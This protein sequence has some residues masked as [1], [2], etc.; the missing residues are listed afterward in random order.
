MKFAQLPYV[1]SQIVG[2]D[3]RYYVPPLSKSL[4]T[5]PPVSP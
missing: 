4:G 3:K 2:G 1:L 5:C